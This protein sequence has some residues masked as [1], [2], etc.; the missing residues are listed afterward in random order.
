MAVMTPSIIFYRQKKEKVHLPD[1]TG[2]LYK[3]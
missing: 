1:V 3:L 2:G